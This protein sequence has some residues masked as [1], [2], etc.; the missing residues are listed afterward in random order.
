ATIVR[1]RAES[2][3]FDSAMTALERSGIPTVIGR[4]RQ[5]TDQ[6]PPGYRYVSGWQALTAF[7]PLTPNNAPG[8]R[9]EH[10]AVIVRLKDLQSA[11]RAPGSSAADTAMYTR[12]LERVIGHE[13]Y[14]HLMPQLR[15]G[16]TAP[17][18]CDDPSSGADWY[19]A[20]VMRRERTV[21]AQLAQAESRYTVLG[22][23]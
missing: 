23:H 18:A 11:L 2:P 22:T 10:I 14:G 1:M 6:L 8:R 21:V 12:Y 9:I 5:L 17:I 7:Y 13:I 16:R 15:L 4:A 19:T 3:A 20:C